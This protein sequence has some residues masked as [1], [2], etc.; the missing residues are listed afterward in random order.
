MRA[1]AKK[2][3]KLTVGHMMAWKSSEIS[4]AWVNLII[5]NYLSIYASDILGL[6]V[7][8]V[9]TLLL[10][11]KVFDAITDVVAGWLVDNTHSKLGKGRPYEIFIVGQTICT[12]LLFGG[13]AQ[14]SYAVKCIWVVLMYALVNSIFGTLRNAAQNVYTIRH[15]NNNKELISKQAA[16]GSIV[17]MFFTIIVSMAFPMAMGKL[18]TSDTGWRTLVAA[19]M[20]PATVIGVFRFIFCKEV[21]ID[22][23]DE[24]NHK[25]G[26]KDFIRLLKVNKYVWIYALIMIA[27]SAM[28]N[29]AAGSYYFTYVV[30]NIGLAGVMSMFSIVMLPVMVVFPTL[31]KKVGSLGKMVFLT[32][33]VGV[34]GYAIC[35]FS[36][37]WLPGVFAGSLLGT[38]G[39]MPVMY[40]GSI[41]IM[42]VCTY[43]EMNG[44]PRMEGIASAFINFM[45]KFG[46]ALGSWVTGFMLMI[47]GYI[48]TV[49][50]EVVTQ[51]ASAIEMIR[52]DFAIMPLIFTLIIGFGCRAFAKGEKISEE[53]E[54]T[55]KAVNE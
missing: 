45:S 19:L 8:L 25:V 29:L 22:E 44:V 23:S 21:V 31:M 40:F 51:P 9:G 38:L 26:F 18:A 11:S 27:Y 10:A 24:Q 6:N 41:F 12:I 1:K 36:K 49:S 17:V 16:Y 50:G 46:S 4:S 42:N 34:L 30:G 54:R 53:Y 52:V 7:A 5:M 47:G 33:W 32:S 3:N 14:W 15:F 28:T 37:A 13:N 43:N 20:I 48:S 55:N 39:T 35:Y 2:Q